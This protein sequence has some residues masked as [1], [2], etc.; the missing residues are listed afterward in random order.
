MSFTIVQDTREQLG[1]SFDMYSTNGMVKQKLDEGDYTLKE[2][3]ELEERTGRKILRIERKR[4]TA[5]ISMNFGYKWPVFSK[6]LERLQSYEHKVI[7]FEFSIETLLAFPVGSGIPQSKWYRRNKNGQMVKNIRINGKYMMLKVDDIRNKYGIPVIFAGNTSGAQ[8]AAM[9][10]FR[11]VYDA[12]K[13][14]IQG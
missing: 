6:E 2:L 5:E 12:N 9:E 3:L 4:N 11:K 14:E 8:D 13:E 7:I 1:W 10:L